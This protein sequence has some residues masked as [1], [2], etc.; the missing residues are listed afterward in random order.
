M[1]EL[2]KK[3]YYP[4]TM[5]FFLHFKEHTLGGEGGKW[6]KMKI[7]QLFFAFYF[8]GVAGIKKNLFPVLNRFL[9]CIFSKL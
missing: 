2:A 7:I 6:V 5:C 9:F 3:L 8:F 4:D 1:T